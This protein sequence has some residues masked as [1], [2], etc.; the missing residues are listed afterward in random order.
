MEKSFAP[1]KKCF[2]ICVVTV[3]HY[4]EK[5]SCKRGSI[6]GKGRIDRHNFVLLIEIKAKMLTRMLRTMLIMTRLVTGTFL[7]L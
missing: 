3:K 7:L 2:Q 6:G 1:K 5:Y 4:L